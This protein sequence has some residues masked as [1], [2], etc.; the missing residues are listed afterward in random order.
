MQN[1]T[2]SHFINAQ[3]CQKN[4]KI[5]T[6]TDFNTS[7]KVFYSK[8]KQRKIEK[9]KS[10]MK[11]RWKRKNRKSEGEERE[12]LQTS[13]LTGRVLSMCSS[14]LIAFHLPLLTPVALLALFQ[15]I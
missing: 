2:Q 5:L 8:I 13:F 14:K 15:E 4:I 9:K 10:K 11:K 1:I 3:M 7:T 12:M 6:K